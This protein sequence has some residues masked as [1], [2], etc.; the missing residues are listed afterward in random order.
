[1][2]RS[3]RKWRS[4]C[5]VL[6]SKIS[7]SYS[8][9]LSYGFT[10]KRLF[11]FYRYKQLWPACRTVS[12]LLY[13]RH[14]FLFVGRVWLPL[15]FLLYFTRRK[16]WKL[17]I[18]VKKKRWH[19]LVLLM[20][21]LFISN[22][23]KPIKWGSSFLISQYLFFLTFSNL[24]SRFT[25]TKQLVDYYNEIFK[26]LVFVYEGFESNMSAVSRSNYLCLYVYWHF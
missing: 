14:A 16:L 20:C 25:A 13:T 15:R 12:L 5:T 2:D 3:Y 21:I 23:Y 24:C 17:V 10:S 7:L 1:M 19:F 11:A 18:C 26:Y 4:D 8:E 22:F 6:A 9:W